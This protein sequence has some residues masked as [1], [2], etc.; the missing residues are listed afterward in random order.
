MGNKRGLTVATYVTLMRFALM[1]VIV[2]FYFSTEFIACGKLVAMILFLV[3]AL[4][5]FVD[6][7]IARKFNQVTNLGK[8]LDPI[9]DKLLTFLGFVLIFTD[10]TLIGTLYP[11]WFAFIVFFIATLRDYIT[12]LLRQLAATKNHVMA[13]DWYAK[14]KSTVQYVGIALAMFYAYYYYAVCCI[15]C[16]GTGETVLRCVVMSILGL[17]AILSVLSGLSYIKT[18]IK[19]SQSNPK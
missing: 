5:D 6:G 7:W 10:I 14:I 17:S 16:G 13:A 9:A 8:L 1:P 18:Y 4:T 3:A 12:N 11:V 19:I 2:F 15:S